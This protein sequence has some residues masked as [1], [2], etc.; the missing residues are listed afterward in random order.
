MKKINIVIKQTVKRRLLS[1]EFL[2][3]L[4]LPILFMSFIG[5]YYFYSSNQLSDSNIP[6]LNNLLTETSVIQRIIPII[7]TMAIFIFIGTCSN[8]IATEIGKDKGTKLMEILQTSMPAQNYFIAKLMSV[9]L[10]SIFQFLVYAGYSFLILWIINRRTEDQFWEEFFVLL[11]VAFTWENTFY[12]IFGIISYAAFAAM[13]GS[14]VKKKEGISDAS[15]PILV[16]ALA[17]VYVGLWIANTSP[18]SIL[19]KV[20]SIF[21]MFSP[22]VMPTRLITSNVNRA[23]LFASITLLIF[24]TL[25]ILI[26][27]LKIY[28]NNSLNY[29]KKMKLFKE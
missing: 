8:M 26:F 1:K 24:Y 11:R 28:E 13:F 10:I 18:D 9:L 7:V 21:P 16:V 29:S 5:I 4:S 17:G 12:L 6:N 23:S 27:S 25:L 15:N 14:L 3:I 22:F 20:M 19:V 2:I